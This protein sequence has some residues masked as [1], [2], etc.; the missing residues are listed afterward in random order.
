M[1][2]IASYA[3]IVFEVS[4]NKMLAFQ[5]MT[6]QRGINYEEHPRAK[7]HPFMEFTSKQNATM[8]L[9]VIAKASLGVNPRDMWTK[10]ADL[11]D[12]HKAAYFFLGVAKTEHQKEVAKKAGVDGMRRVGRE[13]WVI[14]DITDNFKAF[15]PIGTPID[16]TFDITL[17]EYPYKKAKSEK[18][19][20]SK[21]K[22][23]KKSTTPAKKNYEIYT[24][25]KSDCLWNLAEKYYGSG[26]K[27]TKIF[28]ANKDGKDGTHK[29]TNPNVLQAGWKIKIP[30]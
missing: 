3:G 22:K 17:K 27:Y 1:G 20:N 28:N 16:M 30:K 10:F 25:K 21:K 13:R 11:R 18:A 6:I 29:L 26:S 9:E 8:H 12:K 23:K 15:N 19:S 24:V 14:T 2:R 5:N 7:D 4:E